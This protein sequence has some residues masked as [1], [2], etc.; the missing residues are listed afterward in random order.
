MCGLVAA[1]VLLD[2]ESKALPRPQ[3]KQDTERWC[4]LYLSTLPDEG[5]VVTI[6]LDNVQKI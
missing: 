3:A 2:D 5:E 1:N 6:D 4:E